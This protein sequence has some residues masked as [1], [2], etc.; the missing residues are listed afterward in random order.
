VAASVGLWFDCDQ[1]I[2]AQD[3]ERHDGFC[4]EVGLWMTTLADAATVERGS[5]D[6]HCRLFALPAVAERDRVPEGGLTGHT[7]A[8]PELHILG[9]REL[10]FGISLREVDAARHATS[11]HADRGRRR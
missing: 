5:C 4:D 10:L 6:F 2:R 3:E 9:D 11:D 7:P 1:L 8:A